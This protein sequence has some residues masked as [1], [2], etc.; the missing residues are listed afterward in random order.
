MLGR[1]EALAGFLFGEPSFVGGFP[2]ILAIYGIPIEAKVIY[3][4]EDREESDL[5]S[6]GI[7]QSSQY[8]ALSRIAFLSVLDLRPRT[9]PDSLS[10]IRNDVKVIE[11]PQAGGCPVHIVRVQ[12]VCGYGPPSMVK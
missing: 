11:R 6:K 4:N 2:D 3:E 10:N 7:G 8:A 5:L 12:H 1:D 9:E